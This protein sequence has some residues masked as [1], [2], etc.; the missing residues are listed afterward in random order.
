MRAETNLLCVRLLICISLLACQFELK[1]PL[2]NLKSFFSIKC[3][4]RHL[5][6]AYLPN[7][8]ILGFD[9]GEDSE[10]PFGNICDAI[11]KILEQRPNLTILTAEGTS[12]WAA[13]ATETEAPELFALGKQFPS[14]PSLAVNFSAP[15]GKGPALKSILQP[16]HQLLGGSL[17]VMMEYGLDIRSR[18]YLGTG[19]LTRSSVPYR[20]TVGSAAMLAILALKRLEFE[21]IWPQYYQPMRTL[22]LDKWIESEPVH[23]LVALF[24]SSISEPFLHDVVDREWD[25][26]GTP[27]HSTEPLFL[28]CLRGSPVVVKSFLK[29]LT[30]QPNSSSGLL[31]KIV[32]SLCAQEPGRAPWLHSLCEETGTD[33]VHLV[34]ELPGIDPHVL[35]EDGQE[36]IDRFLSSLRGRNVVK[37]PN[38]NLQPEYFLRP[39]SKLH[40]LL[41]GAFVVP[42]DFVARMRKLLLEHPWTTEASGTEGAS[43]KKGSG[44]V[45][46]LRYAAPLLSAEHLLAL[47]PPV[48]ESPND[49]NGDSLSKEMLIEVAQNLL[50]NGEMS[51]SIVTEAILHIHAVGCDW[52]TSREAFAMIYSSLGPAEAAQLLQPL[53]IIP[54]LFSPTTGE[55]FRSGD[56]ARLTHRSLVY[57][58]LLRHIRSL[59]EGEQDESLRGAMGRLLFADEPLPNEA[60]REDAK[61]IFEFWLRSKGFRLPGPEFCILSIAAHLRCALSTFE[62]LNALAKTPLPSH[63]FWAGFLSGSLDAPSEYW[64][65]IFPVIPMSLLRDGAMKTALPHRLAVYLSLISHWDRCA[66]LG[67]TL[68]FQLSRIFL[69]LQT[70]PVA[71]QLVFFVRVGKGNGL[72]LRC[73]AASLAATSPISRST[74]GRIRGQRLEGCRHGSAF[75]SLVPETATESGCANADLEAYRH[76]G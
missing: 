18:F 36:P 10:T 52:L 75:A 72:A 49:D 16:L 3:P 56:F 67:A 4:N 14:N 47:L 15:F 34:M 7:L 50:Q 66:H 1:Y 35:D 46:F 29:R 62:T 41:S 53:R 51:E 76:L 70:C 73:L 60:E 74:G 42:S 55:K 57:P 31:A 25:W 28:D 59:K 32:Q 54:P 20:G 44:L 24:S 58:V 27:E 19:F 11:R 6:S 40:L 64:E 65:S 43:F 69:H 33:T 45:Q 39:N 21:R 68:C 38:F 13:L 63:K 8:E 37:L 17:L 48:A 12:L 9:E 5:L 61:E 30:L 71:F 2:P 26:L 22:P 23:P